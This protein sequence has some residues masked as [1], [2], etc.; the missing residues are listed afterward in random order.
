MSKFTSL[1]ACEQNVK[2]TRTVDPEEPKK[3][4]KPPVPEEPGVPEETEVPAADSGGGGGG[5]SFTYM[6]M[7]VQ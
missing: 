2:E 3:N 5:G 7:G 6:D 4:K 1:Q